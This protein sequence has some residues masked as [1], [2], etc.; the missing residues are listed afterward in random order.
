MAAQAEL[1]AR[2]STKK[3][4]PHAPGAEERPKLAWYQLRIDEDGYPQLWLNMQDNKGLD[5]VFFVRSYLDTDNKI[6]EE[7]Y[8]MY[9][10]GGQ[11]ES[12]RYR[13]LSDV[14]SYNVLLQNNLGILYRTGVIV[15]LEDVD[16]NGII[17]HMTDDKGNHT[18]LT[19]EGAFAV[20]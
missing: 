4:V 9:N 7:Y 5:K 12:V 1:A 14:G 18:N 19:I 11:T 6:K 16:S 20:N 10:L 17:D 13:T 8:E 15:L 2:I 3:P